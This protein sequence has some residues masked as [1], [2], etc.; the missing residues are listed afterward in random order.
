MENAEPSRTRRPLNSAESTRGSRLFLALS[1]SLNLGLL[2]FLVLMYRRPAAVSTIPLPENTIQANARTPR[3]DAKRV[4]V[5]AARAS[6]WAPLESSDLAV[7][8]ANLRAAGC[9]PKTVRDILLPWIEEKFEPPVSELTNFWASFSQRQAAAAARAEQESAAEKEKDK[10]FQELLGFAWSSE[11]LKQAY[12]GEAAGSVGF[13]DYERAEK[14]L[15]IADRFATQSLR[16]RRTDPSSTLYQA[17]RQEAVEVLSPAEVE[18]TELREILRICQRRDSNLCKAGLSGSELRQLM[19]FRRELCDPSVLLE[20]DKLFPE[21]DSSGEQ[22]FYTKA[23][24]LLGDS[25]FIDYL[26]N[27]D[28]RIGRTFVE[29]EKE[30]L[31]RSLALQLFDLRQEATARAQEIR[32]QPVRRAEK[33]AQLAALRQSA[34]EQLA[35]L[36]NASDSPLLRLNQDWLQEIAKP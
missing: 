12:A 4:V 10:T 23:R 34:V 25:R 17:W 36:P 28:I 31:P 16:T 32:Q 5:R 18:E 13:L 9:P 3:T 2:L 11:G 15:C 33:R 7:Y 26:K 19:A 22:Q 27:C 8:A 35:A 30:H 20:N 6:R 29:L 1:L 24:S 21:L 14:L